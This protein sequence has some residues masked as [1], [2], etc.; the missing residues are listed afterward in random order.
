MAKILVKSAQIFCTNN[1]FG[2]CFCAP[3]LGSIRQFL[4]TLPKNRLRGLEKTMKKKGKKR[5]TRRKSRFA[6]FQ[7]YFRTNF[8]VCEPILTK[9]TQNLDNVNLYL[10]TKFHMNHSIGCGV[11]CENIDIFAPIPIPPLLWATHFKLL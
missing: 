4:P 7:K 2:L 9:F 10:Y 6:Y 1:F 5:I 11:I 3:N 8:L